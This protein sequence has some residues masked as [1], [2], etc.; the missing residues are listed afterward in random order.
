MIEVRIPKEIRDYKEKFWMGLTVRQLVSCVILLV[1]ALPIYLFGKNL[2]GE[3]IASWLAIL[4]SIFLG[5]FGFYKH[6]GLYFEKY[7]V[8]VLK[9][10]IYPNK[11]KYEAETLLNKALNY[12]YDLLDQELN[13]NKK[14]RWGKFWRR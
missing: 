11:R 6:N 2:V 8:C 9:L 3:E 1:T 7:L 13:G 5:A 10:Y 12:E 14:K 4:I